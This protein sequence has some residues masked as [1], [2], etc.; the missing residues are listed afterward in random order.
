[1][2]SEVERKLLYLTKG[3]WAT[4]V[5]TAL[6]TLIASWLGYLWFLN[7]RP[8]LTYAN[9]EPI[10][11]KGDKYQ[12]TFLN[13]Y[14]KNDGDKEAEDVMCVLKVGGPVQEIK[15]SRNPSGSRSGIGWQRG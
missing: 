4:I 15:L 13:F 3:G 9:P 10:Q 7:P 8:H 11:F 12:T 5:V 1:M 2:P 14:V 6:V